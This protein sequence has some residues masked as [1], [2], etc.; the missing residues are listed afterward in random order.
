MKITPGEVEVVS[1]KSKLGA[2][3][4]PISSLNPDVDGDGK[5]GKAQA[6]DRRYHGNDLD[7]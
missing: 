5:L 6:A 4:I 7:P 3:A 2:G 1:N